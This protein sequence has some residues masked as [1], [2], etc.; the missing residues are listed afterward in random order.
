[1]DIQL[2]LPSL[3]SSPSSCM[4]IPTILHLYEPFYGALGGIPTLKSAPRGFERNQNSC[5]EKPRPVQNVEPRIRALLNRLD[6]TY[7]LTP[8]QNILDNQPT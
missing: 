4:H 5:G 2:L 6:L 1:M 8:I 7:T 3:S